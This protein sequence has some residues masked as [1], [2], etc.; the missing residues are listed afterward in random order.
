MDA[1]EALLHAQAAL[2]GNPN[3]PGLVENEKVCLRIF[4]DLA[5]AEEGFLK[6]KSRIQ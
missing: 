6:Q 1:R 4:H 2:L 3:D 5:L